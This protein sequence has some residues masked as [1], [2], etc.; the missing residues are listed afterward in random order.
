MLIKV[1]QLEEKLRLTE[2]VNGG[3]SKQIIIVANIITRRLY[4]VYNAPLHTFT[5][6]RVKIDNLASSQTNTKN[7]LTALGVKIDNLASSQTNTENDLTALKD[8]AVTAMYVP[9][10]FS[11]IF[12]A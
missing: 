11:K 5:D 4:Y 3:M 8:T 12:V 1:D 9:R 2:N 6:L 10:L 7:D